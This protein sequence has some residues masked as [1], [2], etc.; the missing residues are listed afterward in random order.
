M[1]KAGAYGIIRT[2]LTFLQVPE[3]AAHSTGHAVHVVGGGGGILPSAGRAYL[4]TGGAG[5]AVD[6][7]G[8]VRM[9][10]FAVIWIAVATMFIGMILALVQR[11]I[12]RTLA[13]S[14]V[15]QMGYILLGVGCIG[16]LGGEG[17]IGLGGG[18]YHIINHAFFKGCFFL[19]AGS[20]LFCAHELDM[21]KLGGLWRRMPFTTLCWCIAALGIMGI[22]LFNGFV[23]KTLIHHAVVESHHLAQHAHL[24]TAGWVKAAE[25]MFIITSGGT[26]AYITKMTYYTFFRRPAEEYREHVEH[27]REAPRWMLA[28]T[29]LLAA[30]V[31]FN[32]FFPGVLLGKLVGPAAET[33]PGFDPHAAE[34]VAHTAIFIWSN[35]KEI[36]VPLAIGLGVFVLG[37]WPDL[38]R[39]G[40]VGPDIFALRLPRW[41]GVDFWYVNA[42]RGAL[43]F[44]F[45]CRKV[46]GPV[47]ERVVAACKNGAGRIVYLV[48]EVV[49]PSVT[50]RPLQAVTRAG[51]EVYQRFREQ[52]LPVIR[53]YQGDLAVGALVIAVS[54]TLFLIIRLL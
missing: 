34:H 8:N 9:L 49:Y 46:Y 36:F 11:D 1:I 10:G 6:L 35:L 7:A 45:F 42:A 25:I 38:F 12:K 52:A 27:V 5:H 53:E 33:V 4:S 3:A 21:F 51:L 15:S 13:Y 28:G 20:V 22:P 32:G 17:A 37:A 24:A 47:K 18:L 40:R 43:G 14:S 19:A 48:R 41:L 30:G 26:I 16:Y 54:L 44:L 31:V 29:A 50:E 2:L 23:S 39:R